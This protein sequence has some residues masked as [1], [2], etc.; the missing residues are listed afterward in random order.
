MSRNVIACRT[1]IRFL[2]N[3]VMAMDST[4]ILEHLYVGSCPTTGHD[5]EVLHQTGITA[6]L[7]LQTNEDQ[8]ST[9]IDWPS[10]R[11][12]Y[13]SNGIEVRRIRVRDFDSED[14]AANLPDCVRAL[15]ELLDG[16]QTVYLHCTGG[17]GR[18]PTVAIAYLHWQSGMTLGDAYQYVRSR[19]AC[20]PTLDESMMPPRPMDRD[21]TKR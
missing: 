4:K 21:R 17:T 18:S 13:G 7:N 3:G 11:A 12:C 5:I 19:R 15:R 1:L 20:S 2:G 10:L 8:A 14:L 6:I 9:N 16:G